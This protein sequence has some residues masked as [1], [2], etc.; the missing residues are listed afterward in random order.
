MAFPE[1]KR[2]KVPGRDKVGGRAEPGAGPGLP[3]LSGFP[4]PPPAWWGHQ[5]SGP[6]PPLAPTDLGV[7][8]PA[9]V[10]FPEGPLGPGSVGEA[11]EPGGDRGRE[12]M[13]REE[14]KRKENDEGKKNKRKKTERGRNEEI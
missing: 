13:K 10:G 9:A 3:G 2:G 5:V 1:R 11:G 8:A 12:K 7:L 4:E 6:T 14:R